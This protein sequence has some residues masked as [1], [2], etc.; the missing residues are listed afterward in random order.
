MRN[1]MKELEIFKP[2]QK[3]EGVEITLPVILWMN[4]TCLCLQI[5]QTN[6]GFIISDSGDNFDDFNNIAEYYFNLFIQ[7]N[8]NDHFDIKIKNSLIYKNYTENYSLNVAINE[9]IR[10]FIDFDNFIVNNNIRL[11]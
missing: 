1:F 10:F 6:D 3:N 4:N 5:S 2:I 9:F 7:N 11:N 8:K